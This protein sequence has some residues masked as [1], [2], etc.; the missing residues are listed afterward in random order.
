[1]ASPVVP[2]EDDVRE[3]HVRGVRL[4]MR[5]ANELEQWRLESFETKEPD[6]LN[7]LERVCEADGTFCDV[8]A[9]IGQYALFVARRTAAI[10]VLAFEPAPQNVTRLCCN[11][12]LNDASNVQVFA[13]ALAHRGGPTVLHLSSLENGSSMHGL[14]NPEPLIAFGEMSAMSIHVGATTLDAVVARGDAPGPTVLK[15]DVDGSE[16]RVLQ[17]ASR[18]LESPRLRHVMVEANWTNK[19]ARRCTQVNDV[20]TARGFTRVG[21]GTSCSRHRM[22]WQNLYYERRAHPT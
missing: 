6:L 15:I 21:A 2:T 7:W 5:C 16:L 1:M 19:S 13:L 17:G 3:V 12:R 4:R 9:N 11:V 14:D 10:K 18:T 8:G 22:H 20:L